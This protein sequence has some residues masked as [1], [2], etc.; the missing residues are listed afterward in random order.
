M[1]CPPTLIKRPSIDAGDRMLVGFDPVR[2]AGAFAGDP[3]AGS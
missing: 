1:A 2:E 3:T